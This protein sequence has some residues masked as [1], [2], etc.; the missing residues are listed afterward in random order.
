[1][2]KYSNPT[3]RREIADYPIGGSNRGMCVFQIEKKGNKER[4]TRQTQDKNGKWCLP[5]T[6]TYSQ[7][8]CIV[9]GDDGRTYILC[10]SEFGGIRVSRSDGIDEENVYEAERVKELKALIDEAHQ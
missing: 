9:D 3:M 1:M 4:A 10:E 8:Q 6:W 2:P 5:K 7:R